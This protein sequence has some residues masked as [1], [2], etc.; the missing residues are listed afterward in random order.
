VKK[1]RKTLS[2]QVENPCE[3]SSSLSTKREGFGGFKSVFIRLPAGTGYLMK[4][5]PK[6]HFSQV[7]NPFKSILCLA[8]GTSIERKRWF[9][10]NF[11]ERIA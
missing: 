9:F 5:W 1:L 10:T 11:E 2:S 6:T 4:S 8:Q 7:E 3:I